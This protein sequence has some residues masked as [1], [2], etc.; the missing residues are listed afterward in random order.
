M[1][2][3]KKL[4]SFRCA[5]YVA[6]SIFFLFA[7][8]GCAPE[9]A[10][11][12]EASE[13]TVQLNPLAESVSMDETTARLYYGFGG[14]CLLAG[15]NRKISVPVNESTEVSIL[16][17]LIRG[18]PSAGSIS[19]TQVINPQTTVV[20]ANL[21][22]QFMIV[23][24]S[25]EFL[26]SYSAANSQRSSESERI[27]RYLAVYSVVNTLIE[28]GNCSRVRILI[29]EDGTGAGRPITFAEAGISGSGDADPF[30]HN[31][32][33]ELTPANSMREL[34]SAVE[35]RDWAQAYEF[36]AYKNASGQDRPSL[37]EFRTQA[38]NARCTVSGSRV[39]DYVTSADETSV[40]VMVTYDLRRANAET[41]SYDNVPRTLV[42]EN[43]I[44][45]MTWNAFEQAFLS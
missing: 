22:G 2:D 18:G 33:I 17:E 26:E 27:R 30:A 9:Q 29:D 1:S 10:G 21:E 39:I 42:L 35:R 4:K 38:E 3:L 15:E 43:S 12:S 11:L 28:R 31:A 6:A 8:A 41:V 44:W 37:E 23:T 13:S 40:V 5:A 16:N 24:F 34:L 32:E 19:L 45:K 14:N 20:G 25:R 36:I 7:A